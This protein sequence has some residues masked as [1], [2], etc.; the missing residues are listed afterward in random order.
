MIPHYHLG[1]RAM[2]LK[3]VAL[4]I[5]GGGTVGHATARAF[6][7]HVR[8]VRMFDIDPTRRTAG[9]DKTIM[10][11]LVF[12]CLPTPA[13]ADGSCDVSALDEWFKETCYE[14]SVYRGRNWVIKST[15]PVGYTRRVAADFGLTNLVHSPE[16]LTARCAVLDASLPSRNVIGVPGRNGEAAML[17]KLY[18]DRWP[19]VP[20]VL[21]DSDTSEA[22]KLALNSFFAVKVAYWNEVREFAGKAGLDWND[23]MEVVRLDGR[24]HPSHTEVPGP[25]GKFGFGGACLP[26]DL[27]NLA[28]T[29]EDRG[30]AAHVMAAAITRNLIDRGRGV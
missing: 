12:V 15:V 19:H 1:S 23:L 28:G 6:A 27:S 10:S 2:E 3:D 18:L 13:A 30:V 4:G 29:L 22:A 7:E 5:V 8:E 14:R 9:I 26:K 16:F 20:L 17:Q 25:D 11:D 21:T 24:V